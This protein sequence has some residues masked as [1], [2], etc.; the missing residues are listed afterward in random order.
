[1]Y[2][3]RVRTSKVCFNTSHLFAFDNLSVLN[4]GWMNTILNGST[5]ER[6]RNNFF[7]LQ[8]QMR[9]K[10]CLNSSVEPI[11]CFRFITIILYRNEECLL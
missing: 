8:A 9:L 5:E 3:N 11:I 2:E 4:L 7:I 10:I 6:Q 1:M